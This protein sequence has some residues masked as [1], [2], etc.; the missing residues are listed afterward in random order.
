M[1]LSV[2]LMIYVVG[3][4]R[5]FDPLEE[6]C[7]RLRPPLVKTTAEPALLK[8]TPKQLHLIHHAEHVTHFHYVT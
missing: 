4:V 5:A 2:K 1:H 8:Q 3:R 7:P 6:A